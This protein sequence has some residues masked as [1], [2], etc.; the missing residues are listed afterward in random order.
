VPG[1][2]GSPPAAS[3][4]TPPARAGP[5]RSQS[6]VGEDTALRVAP[7]LADLTGLGLLLAQTGGGEPSAK[8]CQGGGKETRGPMRMPTQRGLTSQKDRPNRRKTDGRKSPCPRP[9]RLTRTEGCRVTNERFLNAYHN[10]STAPS[11]DTPADLASFV[12]AADPVLVEAAELARVLTRAHQGA[13]TQLIG[14]GGLTPESTS[15]S[16]RSTPRGPSTERRPREPVSTPTRTR[17]T[18][19]SGSRT[20]SCAPTRGGGTSARRSI[21]INLCEVGWPSPSSV[22]RRDLRVHPGLRPA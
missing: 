12:L 5:P 13:A 22:R 7:E 4:H 15:P 11:P 18:G 1:V 10:A 14:E 8:R 21:T 6:V 9:L 3:R 2:R 17:S 20:R 19:R 16:R